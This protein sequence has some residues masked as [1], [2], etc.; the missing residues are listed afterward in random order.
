MH[1]CTHTFN[2]SQCDRQE[3]WGRKGMAQLIFLYFVMYW[4]LMHCVTTNMFNWTCLRKCRKQAFIWKVFE[5]GRL[6]TH[7][8]DI[9]SDSFLVYRNTK[10]KGQRRQLFHCIGCSLA[11]VKL[12]FQRTFSHLLYVSPEYIPKFLG[13]VYCINFQGVK[14]N[15][16]QGLSVSPC[17]TYS[18]THC[19]WA[20][21]FVCGWVGG[22]IS[23]FMALHFSHEH[24]FC[25]AISCE[26]F[27]HVISS[28]PPF[29]M[30]SQNPSDRKCWKHDLKKSQR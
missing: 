29:K 27:S 19:P 18:I 6:Q 1:I 5:T 12:E 25:F 22:G 24:I 21:L 17:R 10:P 14:R 23:T 7:K 8:A 15:W 4:I 26:D 30:I 13:S 2:S 20:T 11:L 9:F 28:Q 3:G 16:K